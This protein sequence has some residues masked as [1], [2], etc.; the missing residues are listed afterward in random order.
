MPKDHYVSQ[1][2]LRAFTNEDSLLVPYYKTGYDLI[3]KPKSTVSVCHEKDGDTNSYFSDP[4]IV[5]EYLRLFE[6]N[7]A[8]HIDALANMKGDKDTKYGIAGY[9]SFLRTCNPTAKRM[10]QIEIQ[11]TQA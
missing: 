5:D 2:Y 7:W 9:I 6:N 1:T 3:G 11:L 10:G 8:N 4:R